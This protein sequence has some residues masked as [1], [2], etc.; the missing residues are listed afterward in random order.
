[1]STR[2]PRSR[3]VANLQTPPVMETT[4]T[5]RDEMDQHLDEGAA[6]RKMRALLPSFRTAMLATRPI[7]GGPLHMRPM[8]LMGDLSVF[9]GTLWFFTDDRSRKV[10][11]IERDPAI[12]LVFQNDHDS[13]YVQL[14][15]TAEVVH[16]RARMRELFTAA[17]R[18]YFPDGLD[19]PHLTLIRV[20]AT[21]GAFW[22]V[23]GGMLQVIAA[24]TKSVVTGTPGK[25]GHAGT[26]S[27]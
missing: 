9:G 11:E 18:T 3:T 22:D 25:T 24:F 13:R 4:S 26:M 19:D 10:K 7:D 20:D 15:G 5:T 12:S 8:A 27:M 6:I 2:L 17:V 21:G 14:T 16:D 1:M 23:P